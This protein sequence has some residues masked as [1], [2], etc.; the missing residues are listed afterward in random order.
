M[1]SKRAL[2]KNK[3]LGYWIFPVRWSTFSRLIARYY[4]VTFD[5]EYVYLV[6]KYR[7]I[8]FYLCF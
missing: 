5:G 1:Y 7:F 8:F 3:V 4:N 6:K 2:R